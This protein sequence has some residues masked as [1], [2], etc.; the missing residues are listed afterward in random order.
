MHKHFKDRLYVI[1]KGPGG[2]R[3]YTN[4]HF[5]LSENVVTAARTRKG[6][7]YLQELPPLRAG[8]YF[9]G[10]WGGE[11]TPDVAA[12]MP[13]GELSK[14]RSTDLVVEADMRARVYVTDGPAILVNPEYAALLDVACVYETETDAAG[15]AAIFGRL[16]KD[17]PIEILVMPI[18]NETGGR[19][20]FYVEPIDDCTLRITLK[21]A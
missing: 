18:R 14:V 10:S 5:A 4:G 12:I 7:K 19:S 13:R 2:V 6:L 17:G 1:E 3:W 8:R 21:A 15:R 20:G 16:S 9:D 11:D